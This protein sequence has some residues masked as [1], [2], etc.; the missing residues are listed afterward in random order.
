MTKSITEK[1]RDNVAIGMI[2]LIGIVGLTEGCGMAPRAPPVHPG[3][4]L[5]NMGRDLMDLNAKKKNGEIS[6]DDFNK[7]IEEYMK[8]KEVIEKRQGF[9][10]EDE[11]RKEIDYVRTGKMSWRDY[12]LSKDVLWKYAPELFLEYKKKGLILDSP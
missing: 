4:I 8:R 9:Y 12:T 6:E 11:R 2:G 10:S 5:S 1:I 3:L 7:K